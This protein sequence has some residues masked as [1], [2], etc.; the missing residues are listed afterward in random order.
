MKLLNFKLKTQLSFMSITTVMLTLLSSLAFG[1]SYKC[2]YPQK[3]SKKERVPVD[4]STLLTNASLGDNSM[5]EALGDETYSEFEKLTE[6]VSKKLP[7]WGIILKRLQSRT[8]VSLKDFDCRLVKSDNDNWIGP[9]EGLN[10]A[11]LY[12]NQAR[13]KKDEHFST[14][15]I[16]KEFLSNKFELPNQP[17]QKQ[18]IMAIINEALRLHYNETGYSFKFAD[19]SNI[20]YTMFDVNTTEVQF[21]KLKFQLDQ[22]GSPLMN[23]SRDELT[24]SYEIILAYN[25]L[26]TEFDDLRPSIKKVCV[27]I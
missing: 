14:F 20:L 22:I 21:K 18:R 11:I 15:W 13:F 16:T 23:Y 24:A 25:T 3:N 6:K 1:D 8:W 27:D 2:Y 19:L 12:F 9:L 10:Q 26:R 7:I 4:Y 5:R 17:K